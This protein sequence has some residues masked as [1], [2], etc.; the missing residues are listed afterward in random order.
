[1]CCFYN[2]LVASSTPLLSIRLDTTSSFGAVGPA[3]LPSPGGGG[4]R[5]PAV[6]AASAAQCGIEGR[7]LPR[8]PDRTMARSPTPAAANSTP[9]RKGDS[10]H[11]LSGYCPPLTLASECLR[12]LREPSRRCARYRICLEGAA[13][14]LFGS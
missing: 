1:M 14:L 11:R 12:E 4:T 5:R 3:L 8:R 13:Q 10:C 7:A 9:H 6:T 2:D